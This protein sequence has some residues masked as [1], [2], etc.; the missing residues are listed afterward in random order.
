MNKEFRMKNNEVTI[1]GGDNATYI[2]EE[3]VSTTIFSVI[4]PGEQSI[5]V[6]LVGRGAEATILGVGV[7][8]GSETSVLHTLQ[9]HEAPETRSNLLVKAVL[10]D[11]STF[12]YDGAILVDKN[13]QKTDAYQRN[14]NLL[15]SDQAHAQSK[16]ALEILANDVRCTH[17][18]TISTVN[19]DQLFYLESRG[20]KQPAG[21]L[22]LVEGFLQA[23][24][25]KL[26][27]TIQK[28]QVQEELWQL[29][30]ERLQ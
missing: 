22:L 9:H 28:N 16:P 6:R 13:A 18:A 1:H 20:I 25:F 10:K 17:G 3:H 26:S 27:D 29:L 24:F 8:V 4:R 21:K 30:S 14:E 15:L 23:P 12:A 7:L 2:V 11:A 5:V 19:P